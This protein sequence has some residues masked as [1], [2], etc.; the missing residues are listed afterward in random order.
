MKHKEKKRKNNPYTF[1]DRDLSWLSFNERVLLEAGRNHVPL[2]ERIR[3]LAIYSS[4]LDEFYRVRMPALMALQGIAGSEDGAQLL[5]TVRET[6]VEQQNHFGRILRNHILPALREG[7]LVLADRY[8]FTAFARDVARNADR[9]SVRRL[10]SF[11]LQP[12]LPLYFR[13]PLDV[14]MNR[15]LTGPGR[16][17]LKYYEAGLDLGLSQDPQESYRLFQ[18]RVVNE[19]DRMIATLIP[20][21]SELVD[22]AAAAVDMI[23]R[24][25][26]A[27]VD[28]GT[29]SG[30][31]AERIVRVRPKARVMGIDADGTM[32]AAA[33]RR[34]KGNIQ[35]IEENFERV[36]IPRCDV[37]SASFALHHVPTGRRKGALYKRC[38]ASLRPG[39]MFV[40]A[41]CHLASSA[42][43]Q[44][45]H[46]QAWLDRF[47]DQC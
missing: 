12:D 22:A 47:P 43:M 1:N 24:T 32:L 9:A 46:R 2:M 28:L 44:R 7:K 27:V 25:A 18:G 17:G 41:D 13:V 15:V 5:S 31:L 10:Y 11:A 3:F 8:V 37:V 40:S 30:A 33:T 21:Y 6:V 23:A 14:A 20:N 39:G 19:Y 26:P 36:R 45:R 42:T 16:E 35:T 38:F 4:N 29:G 34:L